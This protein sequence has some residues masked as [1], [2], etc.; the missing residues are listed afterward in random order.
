MSLMKN[1]DLQLCIKSCTQKKQQGHDF[2]LSVDTVLPLSKGIVGVFGKSGAGK[3]TLLRVLAGLRQT[4]LETAESQ[5]HWQDKRID[6]LPAEQNPCL[7][8]T[9][10][11]Q[12]FPNLTVLAN[13]TFVIKHSTWANSCPFALE[14]VIQWCGIEH[15]LT[16]PSTSLSGGEQQRVNLARSLLCGKPIILLDE[17]FSALDW[18]ARVELLDLLVQ[19]QQSY[20]LHFVIVSHSLKELALT[21]QNLVVIESGKIKDTGA[22]DVLLPKLSTSSEGNIFSKLELCNPEALPQHNLTKWQLVNS[23]STKH[24]NASVIY[25][26]GIIYSEDDRYNSSRESFSESSNKSIVIDANRISLSTQPDTLSSMLNHLPA[27]VTE[28]KIRQHSALITVNVSNQSLFAEISQLSL[29]KME[30]NIGDTI[31]VQFKAV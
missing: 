12:L 24:D 8:Q 18:N 29:E 28:I 9:Q 23:S 6:K 31:F 2:T 10:Q 21:C 13:L 11:A 22:A 26:K 17:P 1:D 7:L 27:A 4:V 25:S 3:S 5:I 14:Q 19:L 30:L 15:L 16:Q 20:G